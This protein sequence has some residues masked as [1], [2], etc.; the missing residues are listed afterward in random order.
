MG[1]TEQELRSIKVPVMII[2]GNDQT[3]SSA[4]AAVAHKL[5]PGSEVHQLPI[6][7]Q[8]VPLIPFPEWGPY[9][10]EIA[11]HL[12]GLHAACHRGGKNRGLK[13]CRNVCCTAA[14]CLL[15]HVRRL[16]LR[17]RAIM[18]SRPRRQTAA[19]ELSSRQEPRTAGRESGSDWGETMDQQ[20]EKRSGWSWWYLLLLVQFV[21]CALGALLQQGRAVAGSACRSSTG[22][23]CSG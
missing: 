15:S 21:V 5:I 13:R 4:S 18:I 22:T 3:H 9:E 20:G 8:E 19:V 1:V 14:S 11:R 7:D 2:P 10:E 17:Q 16:A 23:R 6:T 12:C